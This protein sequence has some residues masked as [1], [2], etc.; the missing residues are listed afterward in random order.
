MT[1]TGRSTDQLL[2]L[3][4]AMVGGAILWYAHAMAWD[5][6]GRSPILSYDSAQY[7]LAAREFAWHGRL[8]TPFALPIDLAHHATSP[9][10]LSALQ[11]GLVL[12]EALI[13][14]LAPLHGV[15]VASDPRA[16]LTLIL[17]FMSFLMLGVGGVLGMRHLLARYVFDAPFVWRLAA[18]IVVGF[19]ILLDAEA[20]HFAVAGLTELPFTVLLLAALLGLARGAGVEYPFVFG[21]LLG[22]AGLFR[23]NMLW[24][25]PLFA[26]ASAW[27]APG[28]RR[29]RVALTILAGYALPLA[30]WWFYKWRAF[31][32]P[33]WDLTRFVVWDQVEGRDWFQLYHRPVPPDVP[34]GLDAV[35]LLAAKVWGNLGRLVPVL[36]EGPRGL[37]LGALVAYLFTRPRRP[38]AAAAAVALGGL[39]LNVLAASASIPWLRFVFPTRVVTEAAGLVALWSLLQR[40]PQVS[41]RVR[42]AA[43]AAAAVLA[44]AWGG[45][46]T[47]MA[48]AEARRTSQERGVPQ[49]HTLTSLSIALNEAMRPGES[50][51]SNLGPALAWQTNHPVVHLAHTPADVPACRS[52]HEF[53]HIL[54]VFR[55]HA[56]AWPFWQEIVEREGTARTIPELNVMRERRWRTRDGF[57][58]VWLELGAN[59]S[60][61]AKAG[62]ESGPR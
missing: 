47:A 4:L 49:S 33:T 19:M 3:L 16:W 50:L 17:P 37:W 35:R 24:L 51:M 10:P 59:P 2:P 61:L 18:P 62:R 54:L 40:M 60:S 42:S 27:C 58:V 41:G 30:P 6:G 1:P 52:R 57:D 23:A 7:A 29:V 13:F 31:G 5:L 26:L 28:P 43:C 38:L 46:L 53:R 20:Q 22:V 45:W 9:W 12:A 32:S 34:G 48:H 21:L 39:A 8:A 36:L 44:L 15:P 25:A 11:P 55:S 14:K 56:R